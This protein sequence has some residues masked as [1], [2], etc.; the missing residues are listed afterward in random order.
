MIGEL[1]TSHTGVTGPSSVDDAARLHDAI[2]SASRWSR[3][4]GKY[5]VTHV[6]RDGPAD[7]EWIDIN[8][9]DYVLSIDGTGRQG[10]R[11]LLEDPEHRPRT[12]TS[13]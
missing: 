2:S 3:P 1:S 11:R 13:R 7:K 10:G 5:R 4:N 12:S 6:Y 9:G 8:V